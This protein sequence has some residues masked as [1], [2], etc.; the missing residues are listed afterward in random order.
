MGKWSPLEDEWIAFPSP[1]R[2]SIFHDWK[3]SSQLVPS[4]RDCNLLQIPLVTWNTIR[5]HSV[6]YGICHPHVCIRKYQYTPSNIPQ[7]WWLMT[8]VF[9]VCFAGYVGTGLP[10]RTHRSWRLY[11]GH[12]TNHRDPPRKDPVRIL[13]L[14]AENGKHTLST[15]PKTKMI[16]EKQ[17]FQN[18]STINNGEFQASHISFQKR[19]HYGYQ[20]E[21]HVQLICF[22]SQTLSCLSKPCPSCSTATAKELIIQIR[23][24][25]GMTLLQFLWRATVVLLVPRSF[26]NMMMMDE[27]WWMMDDGWWMRD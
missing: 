13:N 21:K 22:L 8:D 17:P 6:T 5:I 2:G 25:T 3:Q 27:G 1:R 18:V 11:L 24:T 16:I 15:H 9:G 12:P 7:N 23:S 20:N 26:K 19:I 10:P 4:L 14:D